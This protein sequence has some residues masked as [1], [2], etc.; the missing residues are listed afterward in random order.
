[1]RTRARLPTS[2]IDVHTCG[3]MTQAASQSAMRANCVCVC[4][5]DLNAT[6]SSALMRLDCLQNEQMA[7]MLMLLEFVRAQS[8]QAAVAIAATG[9]DKL[10]PLLPTKRQIDK[11]KDGWR[12]ATHVRDGANV[13]LGASPGVGLLRVDTHTRARALAMFISR[14]R[15]GAQRLSHR[16][17]GAQL[18]HPSTGGQRWP[19]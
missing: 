14:T 18:H 9:A 1:M 10:A 5:T 19:R 12:S 17:S 11:R 8:M 4:E 3:R 2:E 13:A 16:A 15:Y 6:Q 7:A